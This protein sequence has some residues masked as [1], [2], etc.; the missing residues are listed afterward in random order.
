MYCTWFDLFL[1]KFC[2]VAHNVV[3]CGLLH[4]YDGGQRHLRGIQCSGLANRDMEVKA[5]T[6]LVCGGIGKTEGKSG[7]ELALSTG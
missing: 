3:V 5:L 4:M 6:A 2:H 7:Q 1:V